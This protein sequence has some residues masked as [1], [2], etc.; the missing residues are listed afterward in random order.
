[1][2]SYP[3]LN[4]ALVILMLTDICTPDTQNFAYG[5]HKS[6]SSNFPSTR[7][8]NGVTTYPD[9][10][11]V[12]I[13]PRTVFAWKLCHYPRR[14]TPLPCGRTS[15]LLVGISV[16]AYQ[17]PVPRPQP[18]APPCTNVPSVVPDPVQANHMQNPTPNFIALAGV[19]ATGLCLGKKALS[20]KLG[21]STPP[22]MPPHNLHCLAQ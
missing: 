16:Q 21:I 10:E 1:M 13:V 14:L 18:C 7:P 2:L 17:R 5:D 20:I 12:H 6:S 19:A 22:G 9:Y 15:S 4:I 3:I 8:M 11:H